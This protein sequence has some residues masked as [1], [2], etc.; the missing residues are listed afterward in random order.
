MFGHGWLEVRDGNDTA[1]DIF[2]RHY[3]HRP[4]ADGR[5]PLLF[6]GPG[7]KLVLLTACARAL[8]AW[9]KFIDDAVPKQ[10]GVNCAVFR[11]EGAG[12]SSDLI[13]AADA[14]A[15]ARWPGQRH[16]TYVDVA[17]VRSPN[18]GYCFICAGWKR[19]GHTGGGKLILERA[20]SA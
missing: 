19:A 18:P 4:Y 20:P 1:R 12:R 15:D 17:K 10:E 14:V 2:R 13:R 5:R 6:L 3:S 11:N 7:E 9:R 8:F 16:Y